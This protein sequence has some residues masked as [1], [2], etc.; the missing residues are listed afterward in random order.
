MSTEKERC[1]KA[2]I[3][4]ANMGVI[5]AMSAC[6]KDGIDAKKYLGKLA[7][8]AENYKDEDDDIALAVNAAREGYKL[9]DIVYKVNDDVG[10][11]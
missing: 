11:L 7:D 4:F 10:R 5:S 1:K 6:I 8:M 3:D 2:L 9:S